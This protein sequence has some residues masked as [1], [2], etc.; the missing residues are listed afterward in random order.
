MGCAELNGSRGSGSQDEV[1]GKLDSLTLM[2]SSKAVTE[3]SEV[4]TTAQPGIPTYGH[5]NNPAQLK[6]LLVELLYRAL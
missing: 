5:A 3:G 4:G 1:A 2:N 6:G